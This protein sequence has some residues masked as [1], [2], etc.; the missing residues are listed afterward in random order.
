MNNIA[1]EL[2]AR[3]E[4]TTRSGA[5]LTASL[6]LREWSS[7]RAP[8]GAPIV[9]LMTR[10]DQS[11]R[12][13]LLLATPYSAAYPCLCSHRY[14]VDAVV[15]HPDSGTISTDTAETHHRP[16]WTDRADSDRTIVATAATATISIDCP[17]SSFST[18]AT[19][20]AGQ[21]ETDCRPSGSG[22]PRAQAYRYY[23]RMLTLGRGGC[24]ASA[25]Y[26]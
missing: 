5:E 4:G 10:V 22:S 24:G 20:L 7:L 11:D 16:P 6:G 18:T 12:T 23:D 25:Q 13:D 3:S 15:P 1:S 14:N 26:W 17:R 8:S 21:G 19:G 2:R 9:R